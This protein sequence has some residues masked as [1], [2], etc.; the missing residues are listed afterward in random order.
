MYK[1]NNVFIYL[2]EYFFTITQTQI[3]VKELPYYHTKRVSSL[4]L[5]TETIDIFTL[6][7]SSK[8]FT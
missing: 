4:A 7:I 5:P 2:Y 1:K 3:S 6:Q 8:T